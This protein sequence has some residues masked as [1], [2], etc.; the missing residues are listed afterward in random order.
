MIVHCDKCWRDVPV[1]PGHFNVAVPHVRY[2]TPMGSKVMY[3]PCLGNEKREWREALSHP[4]VKLAQQHAILDD[5][6][7]WEGL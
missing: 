4:A 3:E 6:A 5:D 7:Y 1:A 2:Q